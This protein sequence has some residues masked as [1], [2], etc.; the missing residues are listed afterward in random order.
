MTLEPVLR[1]SRLMNHKTRRRTATEWA[2]LVD[3]WQQAG[4]TAAVFAKKRALSPNSLTWWR[5]KLSKGGSEPPAD[6]VRLVPLRVVSARGVGHAGTSR[7]RGS[8][9][10]SAEHADEEVVG[11]ELETASG[12]VLRV[13]GALSEHALRTVLT[14]VMEV[15]R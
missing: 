13:R 11:W 15:S 6:S 7:Q 10:D 12:H 8:T 5:W 3:E 1:Y 9:Q 14:S 2:A 4:D